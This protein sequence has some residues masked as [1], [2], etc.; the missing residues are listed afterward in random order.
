[1][2]LF[3]FFELLALAKANSFS[4]CIST[5]NVLVGFVAKDFFEGDVCFRVYEF[6]GWALRWFVLF[7]ILPRPHKKTAPSKDKAVLLV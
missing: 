7:Q 6:H 2:I 5:M 4:T 3:S 1:V